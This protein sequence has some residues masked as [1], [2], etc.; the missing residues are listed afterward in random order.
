MQLPE[1]NKI[2]IIRGQR[3]PARRFRAVFC[4]FYTRRLPVTFGM[5]A[6]SERGKGEDGRDRE[7]Q[8]TCRAF[9]Q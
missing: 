4:R 2:G 7:E 9:E 5:L 1:N 3:F 6:A 8:T